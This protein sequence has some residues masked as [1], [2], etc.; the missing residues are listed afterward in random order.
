MEVKEVIEELVEPE[1]SYSSIPSECFGNKFVHWTPKSIYPGDG[2][3]WPIIKGLGSKQFV[4]KPY[5]IEHE[6]GKP[7]E[8]MIQTIMNMDLPSEFKSKCLEK[9]TSSNWRWIA[10]RLMSVIKSKD[11]DLGLNVTNMLRDQIKR[12]KKYLAS[13]R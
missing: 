1:H 3:D 5:K 4:R 2:V 12:D 7:N 11:Y 13:L 9:F 8:T 6:D 10:R